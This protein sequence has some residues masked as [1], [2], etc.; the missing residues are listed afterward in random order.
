MMSSKL[1]SNKKKYPKCEICGGNHPIYDDGFDY[2]DCMNWYK[3]QKRKNKD[4]KNKK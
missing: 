2:L 3:K 4:G 1:L